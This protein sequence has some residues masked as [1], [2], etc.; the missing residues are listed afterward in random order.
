VAVF[1]DKANALAI[2]M[3]GCRRRARRPVRPLGFDGQKDLR[4]IA[5]EI[6]DDTFMATYQVPNYEPPAGVTC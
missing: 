4:P 2:S 1:M 5:L 3:D 6:W